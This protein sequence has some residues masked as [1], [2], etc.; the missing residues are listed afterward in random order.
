MTNQ[1]A[2]QR[3]RFNCRTTEALHLH[4]YSGSMLRGVFGR[5][6]KKTA[7]VVHPDSD[8][9]SCLLYRQCVYPALFEP[10]PLNSQWQNFSAIPPPY[11]IEPPPLGSQNLAAGALFSFD[12]VLIGPAL[13]Q[14][15]Y[16]LF[17]WQRAL[18]NGL[19]AQRAKVELV[20]VVF[21]PDQ[22]VAQ[23]IYTGDAQATLQQPEAY[24]PNIPDPPECLHIEL[25]TPLR[26]QQQG[27]ILE[28]NLQARDF[29]LALV[30]R[31][32][33]LCECYAPDY[34]APDFSQLAEV[35]EQIKLTAHLTP[36]DW[37]R[38]SNR[39]KQTM[40]FRG[41]LGQLELSGDLSAFVPLLFGGQWWH[42]GNK[43]SFGM[44]RYRWVTATE[45]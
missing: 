15:P 39:Q 13:A 43:T 26:L 7:C 30:R 37:T 21:E 29:L 14:L 23:V 33:L 1:L 36:Y 40:S 17:A 4:D 41:V 12:M 5:A 11:I 3:F 34:A 28:N 35:A 24:I 45:S 19:G 2:V 6:L 10:P 20:D 18:Q 22:P 16:I 8:C 27:K 25:L 44:G 42:V 31:F 9:Q 32:Y 38:Y